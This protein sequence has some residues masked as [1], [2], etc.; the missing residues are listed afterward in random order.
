MYDNSAA[1]ADQDSIEFLKLSKKINIYSTSLI[2]FIGLIGHFL[3]ILVYSQ[4]KF[5]LN[6]SNIYLLFL[7]IN[8]S[9]FLLVYFFEDIIKSILTVFDTNSGFID[10]ISMFNITDKNEIFCTGII[11][12][13]S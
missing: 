5:R 8:D 6:S 12:R 1:S 7:A 3:T 10:F 11:F 4:K 13:L 2:V 9:V